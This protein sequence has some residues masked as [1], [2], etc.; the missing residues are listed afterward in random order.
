MRTR[1]HATS[2]FTIRGELLRTPLRYTYMAWCALPPRVRRSL[3]TPQAYGKNATGREEY[4]PFMSAC[5]RRS[6]SGVA[7]IWAARAEEGASSRQ[8]GRRE[9]RRQKRRCA[10]WGVKKTPVGL[11][12][13]L[14]GWR[15]MAISISRRRRHQWARKKISTFQRMR[16]GMYY[17]FDIKHA[18]PALRCYFWW[19]RSI[20]AA[21]RQIARK[22]YLEINFSW[23]DTPYNF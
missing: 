23:H 21:L 11:W 4:T 20:D 13:W 19:Y 7:L 14:A 10:Q 22:K 18:R 9:G 6:S 5:R 2:T 17:G 8:F 12:I 1:A 15:Q 3:A 16:W